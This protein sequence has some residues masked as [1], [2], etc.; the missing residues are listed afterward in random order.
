MIRTVTILLL[1]PFFARASRDND[2]TQQCTGHE[3]LADTVVWPG[4]TES[5]TITVQT[6]NGKGKDAAYP[7]Q[8]CKFCKAQVD[9]VFTGDGLYRVTWPNEGLSVGQGGSLAYGTFALFTGCDEEPSG[10]A[11]KGG[12]EIGT[13]DLFCPCN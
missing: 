3:C 9:W 13:V 12:G 8:E 10:G 6:T 5:W 4:G 11:F 2:Q 1:L 7:C